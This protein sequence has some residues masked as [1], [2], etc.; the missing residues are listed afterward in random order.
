M[1]IK[2]ELEAEKECPD[3]G[4]CHCEGGCDGEHDCFTAG[5]DC[6]RDCPH[7]GGFTGFG[8]ESCPDSTCQ[9]D[10]LDYEARDV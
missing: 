1:S 8:A 6:T 9:A 4:C 10:R 5:C 3:C 7:C 2:S